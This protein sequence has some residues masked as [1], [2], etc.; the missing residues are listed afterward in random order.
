M[1][2]RILYPYFGAPRPRGVFL[3]RRVS[4]INESSASESIAATGDGSVIDV[5]VSQPEAPC[6]IGPRKG[7]SERGGRTDKH[8][9]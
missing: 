3:Q 6:S 8:C 4:G 2:F 5:M 1:P 7:K 9:R